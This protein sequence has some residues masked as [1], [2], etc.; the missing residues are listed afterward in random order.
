ENRNNVSQQSQLSP[1][2]NIQC[3]LNSNDNEY[4]RRKPTTTI[5]DYYL[6]NSSINNQD[7]IKSNNNYSYNLSP[8]MSS[9]QLNYFTNNASMPTSSNK[10]ND[11]IKHHSQ[12]H[13]L[14]NDDEQKNIYKRV[15]K[16]GEIPSSGLQKHINDRSTSR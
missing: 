5:D 13:S 11:T 12:Q 1:K 8:L 9:P 3:H 2:R 16:G 15:L 14:N 7:S 6:E 10:M 4:D